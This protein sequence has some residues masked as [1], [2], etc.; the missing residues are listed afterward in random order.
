MQKRAQSAS[1]GPCSALIYQGL[2]QYAD[3]QLSRR[4]HTRC[5]MWVQSCKLL[6]MIV[7]QEACGISRLPGNGAGDLQ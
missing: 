4:I 3:M 5:V 7:W 6:Q 1:A 2:A